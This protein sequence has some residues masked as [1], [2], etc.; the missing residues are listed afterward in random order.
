[1][2]QIL[3]QAIFEQGLAAD[4]ELFIRNEWKPE[5]CR[6]A[7]EWMKNEFFKSKKAA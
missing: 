5:A 2:P 1:L 3:D 6:K 7:L 4:F